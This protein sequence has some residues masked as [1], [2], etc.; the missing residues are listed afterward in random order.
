MLPYRRN[1][2]G[3]FITK[4]GQILA[5]DTGKNYPLFPGGGIDEGEHAD[6]AVVRE[7]LEETGAIIKLP[8][9]N[10]GVVHFIWDKDWIKT[11]KQKRR[12]KKFKGEEMYFFFGKV[13]KLEKPKGDPEN[14]NDND[15]WTG[16]M[17]MPIKKAIKIIEKSKPFSDN[18]RI[19]REAQLR[20]LNQIA[21]KYN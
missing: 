2:E 13:V 15:I 18:I 6:A 8:I 14:P 19:Y 5:K 20:F 10:L 11:E 17:L 16:K 21:E 3:Y 1:C 7:A 9:K 12:F 4:N